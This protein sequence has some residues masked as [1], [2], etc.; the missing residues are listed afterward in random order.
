[1]A[2]D[3]IGVHTSHCCAKHGCK[4]GDKD[5]AVKQGHDQEYAC[6]QCLGT[7]YIANEIARLT[8]ELKHTTALASKGIMVPTDSDGEGY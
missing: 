1:M 8:K 7:S 5:C 2:V 3:H 4:Y 6:P